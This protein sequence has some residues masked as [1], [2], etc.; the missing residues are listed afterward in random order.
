MIRNDPSLPRAFGFDADET[1]WYQR[2]RESGA[3]DALGHI[4]D[5]ELLDEIGR[6][7]Q[8]VVF[9]AR[10]P[11]TGREIAVK[12]LSAGAF[13]T[14]EMRV[15]FEREIEATVTL[16]HSNI[17]TVFGT[18]IV[19]GQQLLA[20]KWIDGVPIDRWARPP[21]EARRPIREILQV[22]TV[23]CDAVHHAH[24]RGVIH[25]DL[26]PSNVLVD[27]EN[28][29][30]VLDFGLAKLSHEGATAAT[31]TMTG[32]FLG[33]PAYAAPEQIRGDV[34]A[35]EVRT[36][37]YALGAILYRLLTGSLPFA[38]TGDLPALMQNVLHREPSRPS[39]RDPGLNREIDVIMLKALAK[40]KDQRYPS[41]DAFADDLRRFLNGQAVLAH[42]PS[43]VYQVRKFVRQHRV[44]VTAAGVIALLL[45]A[46]TIV[47]TFLFVRGERQRH[48]A[49]R[50]RDTANNVSWFM[51]KM[52]AGA[53]RR[54]EGG[55]PNVTVREVLDRT[56]ADLDSGRVKYDPV[57]EASIRR[58]IAETYK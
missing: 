15:R 53:N 14:P 38:D 17:V 7:G 23:V 46:A 25:R 16:D 43:T 22:F 21:N 1:Q 18:E 37:V 9:K 8:G 39:L 3:Q 50:E 42:P 31:M 11:R 49:E 34:R 13:A 12:R 45:V 24:Q 33:T 56:A 52:L 10:Q 20:M 4:G 47:S 41:V 40:D 35:V 57:I 32:Q 36:D 51:S 26:K 2:L 29:P 54:T 28:R 30:F 55:N 27:K 5:Y 6:G 44:G 58:A 19:D 48:R